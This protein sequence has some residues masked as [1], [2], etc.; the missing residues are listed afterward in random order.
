MFRPRCGC[1]ATWVERTRQRFPAL[2]PTNR[3]PRDKLSGYRRE[4]GGPMTA[5]ASRRGH[6]GVAFSRTPGEIRPRVRPLILDYCFSLSDSAPP[7][8]LD[9]SVPIFDGPLTPL[10]LPG[11]L[12]PPP[13]CNLD[14]IW[15]LRSCQSPAGCATGSSGGGGAGA[16]SRDPAWAPR[17]GLRARQHVRISWSVRVLLHRR[18][19]LR[20][21][22]MRSPSMKYAPDF[23]MTPASLPSRNLARTLRV[24]VEI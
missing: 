14:F 24:S 17:S 15:P 4:Q 7:Y 11:P 9:P 10:P 3:L 19:L 5:I 22:A 8:P 6:T 21:W 23:S 18:R 2:V 13:E 20:P 12:P 16:P 1:S